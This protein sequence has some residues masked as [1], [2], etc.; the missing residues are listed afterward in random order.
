MQI[1]GSNEFAQMNAREKM[2]PMSECQ[3]KKKKIY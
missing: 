1:I 2:H 3:K